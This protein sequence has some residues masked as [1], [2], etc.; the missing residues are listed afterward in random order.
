MLTDR[1]LRSRI[2]IIV[3]LLVSASC[4]NL[5]RSSFQNDHGSCVPRPDVAGVWRSQRDSQVGGATQTLE[6]HCDC[7]YK[8]TVSLAFSRITEE[9]EYRVLNDQIVLSRAKSETSWP[10]RAIG[11]TLVITEHEAETHEY[12]RVGVPSSCRASDR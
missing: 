4:A 10:F 7:R 11:E 8:M 2:G 3:V 9:G 12:K 6:L 5:G 1:S